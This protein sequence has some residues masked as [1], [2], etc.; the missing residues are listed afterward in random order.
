MKV[1]R[2]ILLVSALVQLIFLTSVSGSDNKP[3]KAQEG[4]PV[5][6]SNE[7]S[8]KERGMKDKD[9]LTEEEGK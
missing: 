3:S 5:A 2:L 8:A 4:I 9:R 6:S 7:E 1:Q